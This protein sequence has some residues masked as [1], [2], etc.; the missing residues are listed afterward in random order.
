MLADDIDWP[1][2]SGACCAAL[3]EI[4]KC[5]GME[6]AALCCQYPNRVRSAFLFCSDADEKRASAGPGRTRWLNR[7]RVWVLGEVQKRQLQPLAARPRAWSRPRGN[8]YEFFTF[9]A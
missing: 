6:I 4:K 9:R 2:E 3:E 5:R 1:A 8:I 7:F